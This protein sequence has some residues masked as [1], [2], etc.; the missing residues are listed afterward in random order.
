MIGFLDVYIGTAYLSWNSR[1]V[2]LEK[3]Y[4]LRDHKLQVGF[5]AGAT[6]FKNKSRSVKRTPNQFVKV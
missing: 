4:T 1:R 2:Q 3:T 6:F 5:E